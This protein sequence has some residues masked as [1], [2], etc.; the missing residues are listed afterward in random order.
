MKDKVIEILK[1]IRDDVDYMNC[2]TIMEE[3]ILSSLDLIS[4]IA[5]L[6]DEFGVSIPAIEIN[7]ENF[8]SVDAVVALLTRLK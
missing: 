7:V 3:R 8:N 2:T 6:D 4:F 1:N 5:E